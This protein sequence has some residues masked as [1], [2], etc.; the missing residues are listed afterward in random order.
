MLSRSIKYSM[1]QLNQEI[2][3]SA[4]SNTALMSQP[5]VVGA[6]TAHIDWLSFSFTVN[7]S[8]RL[9]K[10]IDTVRDLLNIDIFFDNYRIKDDFTGR[11]KSYSGSLGVTFSYSSFNS[12]DLCHARVTLPGNF[13][14][15]R[16]PWHIKRVCRRFR[17][18]WNAVCTRIDL[19]VD[20]YANQLDFQLLTDASK[21]KNVVGFRCG[22]TIESYGTARDGKTVYCGARTA[23]K[24]ARFYEKEGCQRFEVEYKANLAA[25]IFAD[26]LEC[27]SSDSGIVLSSI[28]RSSISFAF[29]PDRNL[30]RSKEYEWWA[31]FKERVT[32]TFVKVNASKP[33]PSLDRTLK[34]IHRNV[35][36]SLLLMRQALG[37]LWTE[38]M[39][40]LWEYEA[41][42]RCSQ[43]D[44]DR[45]R[46]FNIEGFSLSD[47]MN[48]I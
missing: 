30:C 10:L 35:S 28:L 40:E 27:S 48:M 1:A 17:D 42:E 37:N 14:A 36:K 20:D 7:G 21:S 47:L 46:E 5:H 18:D 19:A 33:R 8:A 3:D 26:Y 6:M 41:R 9:N 34:W 16:K 45:L 32:G 13:L 39:L 43:Y 4:T 23:P 11:Y 38:K 25:A 12:D 44:S 29:R 22:K 24:F 15:Q 31:S 2:S